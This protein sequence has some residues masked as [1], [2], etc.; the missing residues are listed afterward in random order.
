MVGD[1]V[2][3][4]SDADNLKKLLNFTTLIAGLTRIQKGAPAIDNIDN[5]F[6][7]GESAVDLTD[8]ED[9]TQLS[10]K[11]STGFFHKIA[12]LVKIGTH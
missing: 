8:P 4:Q 11:V 1:G 9:N 2:L 3:T 7:A 10:V 12:V 6:G 5:L